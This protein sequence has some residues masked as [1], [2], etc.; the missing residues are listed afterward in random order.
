MLVPLETLPGWP[1]APNPSALESLGLLIGVPAL[2]FLII[3]AITHLQFAALARRR[4][5]EATDPVWVGSPPDGVKGSDSRAA[6]ETGTMGQPR[7]QPGETG[8]ASARW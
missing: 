4:R 5:P 3:A 1:P 8:G 2:V 7:K 6:I